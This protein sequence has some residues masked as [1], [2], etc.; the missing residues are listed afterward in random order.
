MRPTLNVDEPESRV[1]R[2]RRLERR[3]DDVVE[4]RW[5]SDVDASAAESYGYR[6]C[7][8]AAVVAVDRFRIVEFERVRLRTRELDLGGPSA[9]ADAYE[10]AHFSR[11]LSGRATTF[12]RP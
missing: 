2:E 4:L 3:C 10:V 5:P 8:R 6:W 1:E 12:R 11:T 7:P 9:R